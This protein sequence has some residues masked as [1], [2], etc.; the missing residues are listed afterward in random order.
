MIH[1]K[2]TLFKKSEFLEKC[3]NFL[4]RTKKF[5]PKISLSSKFQNDYYAQTFEKNILILF[6]KKD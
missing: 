4:K 3:G 5:T 1:K 2:I 6:E